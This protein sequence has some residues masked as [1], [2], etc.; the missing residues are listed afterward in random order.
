MLTNE[1][2]LKIGIP[3]N[4]P[5]DMFLKVEEDQI[6]PQKKYTGFCFDIFWEVL[7]ILE[8]NYSLPYEFH[9]LWEHMTS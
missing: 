5:F 9:H 3:S 6:E 7:K 1:K 4:S 2:P 8:Q